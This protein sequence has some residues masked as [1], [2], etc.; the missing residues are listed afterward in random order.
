M[1][2]H[3]DGTP[4]RALSEL[5]A[6]RLARSFAI[7]TIGPALAIRYFAA[8]LPRDGRSAIACLS[9]R[10]GSISDNRAGGW[11]G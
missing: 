2:R 8:L 5:D 1:L 9:A 6:D 3:G 10:V 7:N 4:E 11:Y